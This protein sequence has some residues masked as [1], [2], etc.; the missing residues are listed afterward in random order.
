MLSDESV[1]LILLVK[2][3]KKIEIIVWNDT[4]YVFAIHIVLKGYN[5]CRVLF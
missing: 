3:N 5:D 2:I 4:Y 1:K